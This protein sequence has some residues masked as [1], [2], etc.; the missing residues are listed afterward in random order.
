MGAQNN[1]SG[2]FSLANISE[3]IK[4]LPRKKIALKSLKK[5]GLIIL[6]QNDKQ[7][8][9]V[10]NEIAP[11]HLE[12]NVSNYKKYLGRI[13]NA[14]SVCLGKYTPMAVTDYNSGS[15]HTLPTLGSSKFSSGLNVND[16][17]K[18]ISYVNLSKKGVAKIGKFAIHLSDFED[19]K[20]HSKSI[21]SRIRSK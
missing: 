1:G 18:K 15:Q 14:G 2:A 19:L 7:I 16:F 17:F 11:E 8:I 6:C 3:N 13:I 5:H 4:N 20:G 21:K 12:L 9:D 10:I